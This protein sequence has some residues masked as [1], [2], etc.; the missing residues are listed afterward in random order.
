MKPTHRR[1][2]ADWRI[3]W[4]QAFA[5]L[6]VR[7]LRQT[8]TTLGIGAGSAYFAAALVI[9]SVE[10]AKPTVDAVTLARVDWQAAAAAALC[11]LGVSNSMFI[12][13]TERFREIGTFKCL[14]ATDGFIVAVF[15]FEG[16]F[17]GLLG[18]VVGAVLGAGGTALVLSWGGS[19]LMA[20]WV[21]S[22]VALGSTAG[23]GLT[24]IA[25]LA[26]AIVAARMPAVAALRTEI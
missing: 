12:A 8:L 14:G 7:L 10:V 6:R 20:S 17:M 2:S 13:V 26:P 22:A 1:V 4:R 11:L 18:S 5:S 15:F 9:R 23:T 16:L 21:L 25:A 19:E 3:A 24:L